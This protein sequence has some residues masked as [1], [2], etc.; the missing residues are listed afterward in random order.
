VYVPAPATVEFVSRYSAKVAPILLE[1]LL[2]KVR[3]LLA[4]IVKPP[5]PATAESTAAALTRF[6][7]LRD[8]SVKPKSTAVFIEVVVS[9]NARSA[10]DCVDNVFLLKNLTVIESAAFDISAV[11][12]IEAPVPVPESEL[13]VSVAVPLRGVAPLVIVNVTPE[14]AAVDGTE[15]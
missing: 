13:T 4:T 15:E 11:I 14:T 5:V 12:L 10:R 3:S 7:A 6:T 9:T 2:L 1:T 8:V